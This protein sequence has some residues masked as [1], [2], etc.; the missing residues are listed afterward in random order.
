MEDNGQ[1]ASENVGS[2]HAE[3]P[4]VQARERKTQHWAIIGSVAAVV[5]ACVGVFALW[6]DSDGSKDQTGKQ[7][8]TITGNGN[9]VNNYQEFKQDIAEAKDEADIREAAKKF[10]YKP[11]EGNGPWPYL[12]L[13]ISEIGLKVRT[14]GELDGRQIGSSAAKSTLWVD[15]QKRTGFN[16][17]S[18]YDVGPVWLQSRWPNKQISKEFFN[19]DPTDKYAGWVY[20]GYL[21]P[22]GHDGKIRSCT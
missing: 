17:P 1:Q 12:V 8:A 4:E 10:A 16:P 18:E 3:S 5:A 19:S 11:A 9:T 6:P 13:N 7:G 2:S 20:A 21:V 22:A 15:C 14:S